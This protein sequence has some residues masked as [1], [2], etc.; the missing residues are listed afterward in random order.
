LSPPTN[1]PRGQ[2]SAEVDETLHKLR[3]RA[4]S[5]AKIDTVDLTRREMKITVHN[6][7]ANTGDRERSGLRLTPFTPH[8]DAVQGSL[9]FWPSSRT[10]KKRSSRHGRNVHGDPQPDKPDSDR[11]GRSSH[12]RP[13]NPPAQSWPRSSR[14]RQGKR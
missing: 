11:R 13:R 12:N 8:A 3:A 6:V 4:L 7:F 2:T 1:H 14:N 5:K 9:R 10:E